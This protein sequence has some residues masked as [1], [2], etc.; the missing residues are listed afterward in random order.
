[1]GRLRTGRSKK[2]VSVSG[3]VKVFPSAQNF[4]SDF[5]AYPASTW[6]I[7]LGV[8]GSGHDHDHLLVMPELRIRGAVPPRRIRVY[9][10]CGKTLALFIIRG[11]LCVFGTC[12]KLVT[13]S[14]KK[15]Y[16]AK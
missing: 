6:Y 16:L 1:M 4:R 10:L 8:K 7:A 13:V 11:R 14:Y 2:R 12:K 15:T 9:G 5:G 3:W